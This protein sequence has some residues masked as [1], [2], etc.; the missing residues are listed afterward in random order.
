MSVVVLDASAAVEIALWTR[1]GSRLAQ[2]LAEADEVAVPDHFYLECAAALRR[3]ERKREVTAEA[4]L[5]A[6]EQVLALQVRRVD[7]TPLLHEAWDLR[8]NITMADALYV[9]LA[10][11]LGVR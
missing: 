6:L 5:A 4:A 2:H 9:V 10:R 7:T 8:E 1:S 11:R 3:L